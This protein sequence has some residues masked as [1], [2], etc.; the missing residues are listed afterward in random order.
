MARSVADVSLGRSGPATNGCNQPQLGKSLIWPFDPRS[1][2]LSKKQEAVTTIVGGVAI[3]VSENPVRAHY[4]PSNEL[5]TP[6]GD[7]QILQHDISRTEYG[8]SPSVPTYI[9]WQGRV[10]VS[11]ARSYA[12]F[13]LCKLATKLPVHNSYS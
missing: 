8:L 6:T 5:R 7:F 1:P 10:R 13:D 12:H 3:S 11:R 9:Y 2:P 4:L